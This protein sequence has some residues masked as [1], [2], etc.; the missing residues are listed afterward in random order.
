MDSI[1]IYPH[2]HSLSSPAKSPNPIVGDSRLS[3]WKNNKFKSKHL[4]RFS[5][6]C[7]SPPVL[8]TLGTGLIPFPLLQ[9][10]HG[11]SPE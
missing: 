10:S 9:Y 1:N 2:P 7:K 6:S 11:D 3:M 8:A 4:W 5:V